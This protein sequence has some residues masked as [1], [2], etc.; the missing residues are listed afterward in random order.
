MIIKVSLNINQPVIYVI[1]LEKNKGKIFSIY[2]Q[3][4]C[5]VPR[6]DLVRVKLTLIS[7]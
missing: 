4:H 2:I 6:L 5:N 3:S 1:E 7:P